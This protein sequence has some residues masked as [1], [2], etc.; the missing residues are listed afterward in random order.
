MLPAVPLI[1]AALEESPDPWFATLRELTG[2]D[3]AP[4][5]DRGRPAV[6]AAHWVA[7]GALAEAP[8]G[9]RAQLSGG[10][11]RVGAVPMRSPDDAVPD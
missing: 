1:L 4:P 5:A 11:L 6:A 8:A 3:P 10:I 9:L 2:A 7:A